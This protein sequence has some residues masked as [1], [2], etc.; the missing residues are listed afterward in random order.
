MNAATPS[1]QLMLDACAALESLQNCPSFAACDSQVL[2]QVADVRQDFG[3]DN[4]IDL[5]SDSDGESDT[6]GQ[7]PPPPPSPSPPPPPPPAPPP[8]PPPPSPPPLPS[9]PPPLTTVS[10]TAFDGYLSGCGARVV[11]FGSGVR[12]E[13]A[14]A[15]AASAT[16]DT[17]G[18]YVRCL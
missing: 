18:R 6:D 9:P 5:T 13:D 12:L 3:C 4:V 10:T 11:P 7:P 1:T 15:L 17:S 2:G 16:T 8:P 14:A